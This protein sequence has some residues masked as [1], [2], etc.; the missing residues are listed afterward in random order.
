MGQTPLRTPPHIRLNQYNSSTFIVGQ[1]AARMAAPPT[2]P[3]MS[4]HFSGIGRPIG[5]DD[6][7]IVRKYDALVKTFLYDFTLHSSHS[8][9]FSQSLV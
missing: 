6:Y 9:C 2:Y 3:A 7:V 8:D 4:V 1:N 5:N